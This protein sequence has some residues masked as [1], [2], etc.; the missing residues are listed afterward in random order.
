[1]GIDR[2]DIDDKY[3]WKIDL[4]YSSQE[5][6]D[7]DI[8][9]I[10][11]YINEIKEYK[12]K[13]SQSKENMYEALNIYEKASQLLQNLYVYTH[14]KQHED[15]RI[16]ENQAMATKTDMLSTELSTASSYMVPEI[17][18]IDES[19]L[20]EYLEDEKLSFYKKYIEEILREKPHTLSEKEEEIL[21]AVSDLTSV[22]EN[23]YDM[24]S[25]ADMDFPK[26]ENE[27]GEMVKLTHS[28][29]STFLKSKNNKV[30]KNAFD[31]MYKTY[32]KYKNT[33]ASMLYGGIKSEI[34]YSK[35][36]KYESALYASLFQ[37]DISVDVYNNLIKAVDENLDTLNRYVD[38]KK[39][40]L[41]LEDIHMYD[42][43]VPLTE[44][45]DMKIP[46]EEAQEI[47]LNALKPL[48][49]EYLGLI[50]RAFE[51]NWI[52]VYE[53]EGKQGG[54]YSWGCYDSKSY[55]LMNYHD[56]LNSL[57]TLIHELGHSMHSTYSKSTQDYLYS[58]YKI[59]VA[60]VASTL[61]ELLLINYLLKKST[62]KEEKIYLLNY[63]LEQ[64]RTTVYRQTMFAE[65]E[66]ITHE[67]VESGEP[68]TAEGFT[69]IYY[70]LNEK[71]YGNSCV[72]DK[73]IGLEWARIPHFYSNFYVYKYATGFS[74]ASALS[75]QILKE[76]E[77][78]V[79]R[80]KEFL[81]SGGSDY[82]LNQLKAA[83]V[84]MHKKESVDEAL[85]VFADL[86]DE[87]EKEL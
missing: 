77:S 78:A 85:S 13:L 8:S 60:E 17:I 28:N 70:K 40:F 31:A 49:E 9:K 3:K 56:D 52:D 15:T 72:V 36:R 53:N 38:I 63:Y 34:F 51:E 59:F 83:G 39:K 21:A 68:L 84:D 86:V 73:Q 87:L 16:N 11:S 7:K 10:K 58:S 29:F 76:G 50:K 2:K 44:S 55:I 1:M 46:Y 12:G 42:L 48:G 20:K 24:L 43:Y 80:Y 22:P 26:I 61:N 54:A 23:A 71:Y 18:A 14:M 57:F 64:F 82:P 6:I 32:D 45:F 19:K 27:D 81:K 75:K 5:S 74:A 25:Y 37:D 47:V 65:F 4:M 69:D 41:G 66:K 79:N 33:F 30:R 35:T 67:T 62:S